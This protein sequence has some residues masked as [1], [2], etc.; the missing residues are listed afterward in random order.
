MIHDLFI[1]LLTS[2]LGTIGFG[3]LLHAPKRALW[4]S[5]VIGSLGYIVYWLLLN[6]IPSSLAIFCGACLASTAA[7]LAARKKQM[8][9]TVF[10]TLSIIPFVPGLGLYQA[11]SYFAQY[12]LDEGLTESVSALGSI[13]M[14]AL[15]IGVGNFLVFA[16]KQARRGKHTVHP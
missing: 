14:I 3:I 4:I 1:A 11:M 12:K 8:I 7:Q 15:G 6:I 5:G 9:A 2:F 16:V 10:I 13:I